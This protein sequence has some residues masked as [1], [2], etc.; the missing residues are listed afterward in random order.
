MQFQLKK[1]LTLEE[2]ALRFLT[3]KNYSHNFKHEVSDFL[4]EYMEAVARNAVS[5]SY[6]AEK[7][8]FKRVWIQINRALPGG[9][10]FRGKNPSDRRS[11]GPFSPALFEMVSIGVAHNI[12]IV[13]KLS[14]EEIGDK[15][16]NLIIK[17]KANVLT[18]SGSNSRSKTVGRLEL[19][20]AGFTV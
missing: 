7:E 10:A 12:E 2:F 11:Y 4:T 15:I 17:A 9:E 19:G 13:E 16:T 6:E 1:G 18:G 20:K 14:P 5:F 3:M 8:L